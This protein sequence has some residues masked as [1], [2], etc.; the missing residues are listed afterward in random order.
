MQSKD[1][2]ARNSYD[3][4]RFVAASA[5]LFSHHFAL[6][7]LPEPAVP[8]YGEDF[9]KL[10]VEVFFS[11]SGFLIC[12]SLQKSSDWAQFV[13][14]RFLRIFPNLAFSL[15][16]ASL[17]TLF[18][19]HNYSHAWKHTKFVI[20]NLLMFFR[21]VTFTIPGVFEDAKVSAVNG[22]LWSLPSELWLYVLLF[23]IF[24]LGGR[25]SSLLIFIAAV[26]LSAVWYLTPAGGGVIFGPIDSFQLA[27]LGS[28]FM[29]GAIVAV[30]WPYIEKR[31]VLIGAMA[32]LIVVLL[33]R[34]LPAATIV[35]S[36]AIAALVIGL[37]SSRA[38][39]WFAKGGDASYGIYIFAWP[40]QQFSLLLID[41]FWWSMCAAFLTTTAL[42]YATWHLFEKRAMSSRK[43]FA[44]TIR[45]AATSVRS[46]NF[47]KVESRSQRP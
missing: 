13:S 24:I 16:A 23:A 1:P 41:S 45:N 21:G 34:F 2:R 43:S 36:L 4:I 32:L 17:A 33:G 11:L 37:G 8:F 7:Q 46:R 10:A 12:R 14:A 9:G 26:T 40:L 38:M 27:R 6:S 15:I 20:G 30:C 28:F 39:A 47:L 19:Y 35:R 22:P 29:C 3:F 31:A 25:R 5:V 44:E 42:G 18:W